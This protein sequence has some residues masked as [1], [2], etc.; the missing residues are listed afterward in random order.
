MSADVDISISENP[1]FRFYL[2][3]GAGGALETR[4]VDNQDLEFTSGMSL[5]PRTR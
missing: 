1:Y 4:V 3:P 2:V 5:A